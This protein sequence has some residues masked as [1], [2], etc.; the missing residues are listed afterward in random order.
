MMNSLAR[1]IISSP[2]MVGVLLIGV[3]GFALVTSWEAT[4]GVSQPKTQAIGGLLIIGGV[5]LFIAG[6]AR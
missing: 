3:G 1:A 5:A 6:I 2:S 4:G